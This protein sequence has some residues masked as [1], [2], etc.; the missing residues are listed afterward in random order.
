ME[1]QPYSGY[2]LAVACDSGVVLWHMIRP[3]SM[4]VDEKPSTMPLQSSAWAEWLVFPHHGPVDAL[5]WS[6]CGRYLMTCSSADSGLI[7]WD[8]VHE[9]ATPLRRIERRLGLCGWS[10]SG[11]YMF[12]A[13]LDR[14]SLRIWET[15]RFACERW[16]AKQYCKVIG[17]R[18]LIP[19]RHLHGIHDRRGPP[20]IEQHSNFSITRRAP[21]IVG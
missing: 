19:P 18:G 11:D 12:S 17:D 7:V 21:C 6:P 15:R 1:W 2:R 8:T 10:P 5:S 14:A 20:L 4:S 3:E 13:G 9:S 16:P